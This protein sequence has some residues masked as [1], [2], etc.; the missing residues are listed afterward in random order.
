MAEVAAWFGIGGVGLHVGHQCC[1]G[2]SRGISGCLIMILIG[3]WVV[4]GWNC[5][6]RARRVAQAVVAHRAKDKSTDADMLPS[7]DN[8]QRCSDRFGHQTEPCVARDEL[9]LPAGFGLAGIEHGRD[10]CAVAGIDLG[11]LHRWR[12]SAHPQRQVKGWR[13][14]DRVYGPQRLPS[15][16]RMFRRPAQGSATRRRQIHADDDLVHVQTQSCVV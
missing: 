16:P 2:M 5:D 8:H 10:C 15:S 13:H 12:N 4:F 6:H 11:E 9:Q 1:L 7:A 3:A 14:I